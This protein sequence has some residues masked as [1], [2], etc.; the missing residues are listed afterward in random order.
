MK[1][2]KDT[3]VYFIE[4]QNGTDTNFVLW[5][6][7]NHETKK[8]LKVVKSFKTAMQYKHNGGC[9][10]VVQLLGTIKAGAKNGF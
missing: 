1:H 2:E 8:L 5:G 7:Y 9:L 6:I 10:Q 4:R 3:C